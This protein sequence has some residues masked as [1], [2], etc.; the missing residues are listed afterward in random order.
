MGVPVITVPG[1]TFASRHAQSHLSTIGVL[2][3]IAHDGDDYLKLAV[4]LAG[5]IDRLVAYR[6][7]LRQKMTASPT[8][9]T[10]KFAD[11]FTNVMRG[12]WRDWCL[13]NDN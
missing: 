4:E 12:I 6:E 1:Q 3:L 8:C 7:T 2:E 5:D 11:G 13:S 9:D 10:K